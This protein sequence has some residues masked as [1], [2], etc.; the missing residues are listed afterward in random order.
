MPYTWRDKEALTTVPT[1]P[2]PWGDRIDT[3]WH[4]PGVALVVH[5]SLSVL[6]ILIWLSRTIRVLLSIVFSRLWVIYGYT[7]FN[8]GVFRDLNKFRGQPLGNH[9][10]CSKSAVHWMCHAVR[11]Q[12]VKVTSTNT[13]FF[14]SPQASLLTETQTKREGEA[15]T[16]RVVGFRNS[17]EASE[18]FRRH[19]SIR[20]SFLRCNSGL[21]TLEQTSTSLQSAE[22]QVG[23]HSTKHRNP[24]Q[25]PGQTPVQKS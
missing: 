25:H 20:H 4:A 8:T 21:A 13:T 2:L 19:F 11:A 3:C 14:L 18:R 12:W 24:V 1:P 17:V 7:G 16:R 22:Y 23:V 10:G 9:Y 15:I 6:G 5:T